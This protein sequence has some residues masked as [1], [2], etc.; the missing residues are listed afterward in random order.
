MI[1]HDEE[2]RA[3][4]SITELANFSL[5]PQAGRQ[6]T[7]GLWRMRAGQAWHQTI[8]REDEA[9]RSGV[10]SE[11]P[12]T[13][14]WQDHGWSLHL[15]GRIDQQEDM[16]ERICLREIKTVSRRLPMNETDLLAAYPA[17]F[18]Q[19]GA[20][21]RLA[22]ILPVYEGKAVSGELVFIEINEGL[23]QVIAL[24]PEHEALFEQQVEAVCAFLNE[25]HDA[26]ARR[27]SLDFT[28]AF[29]AFR[30]EQDSA[31]AGLRDKSTRVQTILLEAPTG[32][33]KTGLVLQHALGLLR[34]GLYERLIYTTGKSTGQLQVAR[35][36]GRMTTS[37]E[38]LRYLVFRNRAEH[39]IATPRHTCDATGRDCL[40][41]SGKHWDDSGIV[42]WELWQDSQ[43]DLER[44]RLLG[45]STGVCPY[46]ISKS[47][48]PYADAWV[49]DYNYVFSPWHRQVFLQTAGFDPARTLL[50]VDEAHNLAS[51]V[52]GL[53]AFGESAATVQQLCQE[54][55]YADMTPRVGTALE[56]WAELLE[57]VRESERL[58]TTMEYEITDLLERLGQLILNERIP[59]EDLPPPVAE[60]LWRLPRLASIVGNEALNLLYW[61]PARGELRVSCLDASREI[62]DQL[63]TFGQ[64]MLMSATLSPMEDFCAETGLSTDAVSVIRAGAPWRDEAYDVAVDTRVDTRMKTRTRYFVK[65][66]ETIAAFAAADPQQPTVSFFPSYRYA[67]S[68]RTY[69][70][71]MEPQLVVAMQPRGMDLDGQL[72]F[73][74]ES[75]LTAHVL[76]FVL[77]SSFSEGIDELGGRVSQAIVVGPALPEVN[78]EQKARLEEMEPLGRAEAF[79]RVY[80][81]PAMRKINQ[82]LGRLVRAPG[83]R[84]RVLLHC[85][86]FADTSYQRLLD[87]VLLPEATLRN[88]KELDEWLVEGGSKK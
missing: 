70:S 19:A 10:A 71:E 55:R 3:S 77:G 45:A 49:G 17:Y 41:L 6:A 66:A 80:Q 32:F 24:T 48:L 68:V 9:G 37:A 5:G 60:Q 21:V 20:Y 81:L 79:R 43:P 88:D 67:E 76:F 59:W 78:A 73:I 83:Q 18:C 8:Q 74:E 53:Y 47:L 63:G 13:A 44:A 51:R 65:T 54:L 25:R 35:Q 12:I 34:D 82:A 87:P 50:I 14:L 58:S 57:S 56:T 75:L 1:V 38:A 7:A 33:G 42:P 2:R 4:L 85:N 29:P 11:V 15:H 72:R 46:E 69:L 64:A 26:R 39:A 27:R 86:R 23:R 84:A 22:R 52:A 61:S 31:L 36:L 62:S 40:E 30:P 28:P 16:G